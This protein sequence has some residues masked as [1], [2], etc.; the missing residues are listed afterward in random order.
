[1][2]PTPREVTDPEGL[3]RYVRECAERLWRPDGRVV[4][5]WL[6][7]VRG[8]P[9][10]I[11]D[12]NGVGADPGAHRQPRPDGI[13]RIFS[14]AA[15]FPVVEQDRA[16][17]A[18]LRLLHPGPVG[19]RYLNA[20]SSLAPNPKVALYEPCERA[21]ECVVVTEGPT[22]GL[23][24]AAGGFRAAAVLGTGVAGPTVAKRLAALGAPL[25]VAF[26]PD[27]AGSDGAFNLLGLLR[28]EGAPASR[29]HVPSGHDDLNDWMRARADDWTA[30]LTVAVRG[31]TRSVATHEPLGLGH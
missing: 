19:P 15:V 22:D 26:D 30:T 9:E 2:E 29:L 16:V 17:F 20:A 14:R 6:T 5:L 10:N 1:M 27:N 21:G 24:A 4:R 7:S 31:A 12:R 3:A 13:P 8:I 11:L 23:S 28:A 25:V 18:Q